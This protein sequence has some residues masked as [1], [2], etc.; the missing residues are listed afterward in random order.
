[1]DHSMCSVNVILRVS[2]AIDSFSLTIKIFLW[3]LNFTHWIIFMSQT[4]H[5]I[6]A[7]SDEQ[8]VIQQLQLSDI[9]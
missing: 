7:T 5:S 3:F 9:C 2:A 8:I 6:E 1:M 4:F